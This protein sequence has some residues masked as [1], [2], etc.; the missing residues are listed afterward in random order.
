MKIRNSATTLHT[1][2]DSKIDPPALLVA[3]IFFAL[4]LTAVLFRPLLPV[5]ETRYLSV[6]WEMY[7]RQDWLAPLTVNFEPYHHKPPLLFWLINISW[8]VFGVSR[9]AAT[10]PIVLSSLA[11]VYL[12][13]AL[14]KRLFP[15]LQ[16]NVQVL[17]IGTFPFLLFSTAILF[18]LTLAVWVLCTLLCLL[19]Y[20]ESRRHRYI[21]L[22]A[23]CLGL[24]VLTK[25]PVVYLYVAFP[26][27]LGPLWVRDM[28]RKHAWY[29]GCLLA[30]LLSFIPVLLWL[31]PV[32]KASSNDFAY[33]L[34]WE[35]T[36]GRISG[37]YDGAHT[38]PFYFYIAVLPVLCLP[39]IFFPTFWKRLIALRRSV[40]HDRSRGTRFL[41]VWLVPT[42]AA[43]SFVSGKQLH[44]MLPLLAGLA[45][46]I[47]YALR[48]VSARALYRT[49][50][51]A[52]I[53]FVAINIIGSQSFFK[54]WNLDPIA[55]YLRTHED[56]PWTFVG[57]YNGEFNFLNRIKE[58]VET[59]RKAELQEWFDTHPRSLAIIRFDHSED[60]A[61]FDM[62]F[63][64]PYRRKQLGVFASKS[65]QTD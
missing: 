47:A 42:I 8:S 7:L 64:M 3:V 25:G 4:F 22:M 40:T 24:G 65:I 15:G 32:I 29:L 23:L 19:S 16:L 36:A 34:V 13:G 6:A 10:L 26:L 9:W 62:L 20:A 37:S 49:T 44:Y 35:Q 39:W 27:L 5:D 17:L 43:F 45:I 41:Q 46:A 63:A 56:Q 55:S 53:A 11:N 21:G 60:V 33:W 54:P 31:V 48:N 30:I 57:T 38:R 12:T 1:A 14:C 59:L 50:A 18:D 2:F 52:L 58:P 61:D 51:T 28:P